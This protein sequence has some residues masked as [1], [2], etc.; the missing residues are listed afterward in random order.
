MTIKSK[1]P[2]VAAPSASQEK[3]PSSSIPASPG[4]YRQLDRKLTDLIHEAQTNANALARNRFKEL[5]NTVIED[6]DTVDLLLLN[7]SVALWISHFED[8]RV[9]PG[10]LLA[11]LRH[12][13]NAPEGV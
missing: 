10:A 13:L 3:E 5:V 11:C 7:E 2:E 6:A 4:T 9:Q 12:N 8:D 1:T